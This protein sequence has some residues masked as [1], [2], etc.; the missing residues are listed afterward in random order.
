MTLG[1]V[2]A[3][4]KAPRDWR[5]GRAQ[6]FDALDAKAEAIALLAAAGAPADRLQV[7]EAVSGIYH[8][9]RSATLRLG[10]KTILA[11]FGELHPSTTRAFDIGAPVIA[12]EIYLDAIPAKRGGNAHMREAFAPPPLQAVRRDFAFLVGVGKPVDDLIRAVRSADKVAIT[13]VKLFDVFTG[14]GVP[15]GEQ[16][17]AIEVMLQPGEKSF[18]DAELQAI[19]DKVVKAA[20]KAGGR[21]RG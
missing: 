10:P 7:F 14:T 13:A 9:G 2:L 20:E 8:P 16:S 1:I 18:T 11:E 17:V 5:T 21:L 4:D 3:G 12:A 19:S 6:P 15:E